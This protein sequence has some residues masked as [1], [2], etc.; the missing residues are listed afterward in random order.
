MRAANYARLS[1][2]KSGLSENVEIQKAEC[3]EYIAEQGWE[4]VG[5]FEDND[6]SASRDAKRAHRERLGYQELTRLVRKGSV[7]VVVITEMPRLYRRLDE[8]LD[9][10]R[11]AEVTP[12]RK[13]AVTDGSGYDLATGEGIHNA[14]S[15]V[16]N[17]VLESRKMSDRMKRK[18]RARAKLGL[19]GGGLRPFG[20]EKDRMT[21]N[22]EEAAIIR[23]LA[24]RVIAGTPLKRLAVEL[25]Q[26]G[27]RTPTGKTWQPSVLRRILTSKRIVGINVHS[28][29]EYPAAWPAILPQ[30]VWEELQLV[31]NTEARLAG[32][33][34]KG[35]RTYLLTGLLYSGVEGCGVPLTGMGA[36]GIRAYGCRGRTLE[37]KPGQFHLRRAADPLDALIIQSVFYVLESDQFAQVYKETRAPEMR[38]LLTQYG[39]RKLKLDDLITDY[40]TGLL[41]REQLAHAKAVVEDALEEVK[42]KMARVQHGKTLAQIPI[43]QTIREAWDSHPELTWRRS[44]IQLVVEKIIVHP[45]FPGGKLWPPRTADA[46]PDQ[47]WRFDP[48]KIEIIWKV[49]GVSGF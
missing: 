42:A 39:T 5:S 46:E 9:L 11:L 12:L 37:T 45:S 48:D 32:A 17:A 3:L 43:D 29:E 13:I 2:D 23:E 18:L 24:E 40:A 26:R 27:I 49:S 10:I 31:L 4:L 1:M 20:Y 47:Q 21:V 41:N 35:W 15:A 22:A 6:I 33:D 8:L 36:Y 25:D 7:D 28:G 34:K 44:L 14:V 30:D 38:D 16:N 19:P